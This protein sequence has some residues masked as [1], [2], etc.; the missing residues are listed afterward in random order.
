MVFPP[1]ISPNQLLGFSDCKNRKMLW[2]PKKGNEDDQ[3]T[4]TAFLCRNAG[5]VGLV[6]H[7]EDKVLERP[8]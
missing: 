6:K 7:G 8:H 4:G 5:E 2:G 1:V 3:G